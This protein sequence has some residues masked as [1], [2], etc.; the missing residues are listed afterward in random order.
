[1]SDQAPA[2]PKTRVQRKPKCETIRQTFVAGRQGRKFTV[3]ESVTLNGVTHKLQTE[4]Y[5]D[6]YDFQSYCRIS[7]WNGSEWKRVASVPYQNMQAGKL[8]WLDTQNGNI[9]GVP[10]NYWHDYNE[11]K[12]QAMAI[13]F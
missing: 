3:V 2:A 12:R 7:H 5:R 9:D 6:S 11:A 13:L 4:V 10:R 1:M 8:S